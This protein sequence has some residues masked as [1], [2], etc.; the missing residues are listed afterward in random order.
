MSGLI[1]RQ[2]CT[3]KKAQWASG[4]LQG[5]RHSDKNN[6]ELGGLIE[7]FGCLASTGYIATEKMLSCILTEATMRNVLLM[8]RVSRKRC[9]LLSDVSLGLFT[10]SYCVCCSEQ[11]REIRSFIVYN[12]SCFTMHCCCLIGVVNKL[13]TR[14]DV[15]HSIDIDIFSENMRELQ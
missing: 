10:F 7:G 9:W 8:F 1:V 6:W 11:Q 3:R 2:K 4:Y 12:S 15:S 5:A 13:L 14:V